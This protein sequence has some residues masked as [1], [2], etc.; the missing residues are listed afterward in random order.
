MRMKYVVTILVVLL[1]CAFY[2]NYPLL[3]TFYKDMG[4]HAGFVPFYNA[5]NVVYAAMF[6]AFFLTVYILAE[7][8]PGAKAISKF[9][10]IGSF[11]SLFDVSIGIN[12]YLSSDV[13]LLMIAFEISIFQYYFYDRKTRRGS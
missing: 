6:C 10:F 5:R 7:K 8:Y 4:T 3:T 12:H 2:F 11:A 13:L 1:G 9:C